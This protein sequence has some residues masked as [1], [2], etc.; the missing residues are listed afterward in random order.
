MLS[1]DNGS[2]DSNIQS[3]SSQDTCWIAAP[4]FPWWPKS[5]RLQSRKS[6]T[7]LLHPLLWQFC[8]EN[9]HRLCIHT[10]RVIQHVPFGDNSIT[11]KR[12]YFLSP[13]FPI[14]HVKIS[15]FK[16]SYHWQ[17]SN[18]A[19]NM[20]RLAKFSEDR[21]NYCR[22]MAFSRFLRC[23][24]SAILDI[25]K[26]KI[27]IVAMLNRVKI[28]HH[29]KFYGHPSNHCWWCITFFKI[30]AFRYLR[31]LNIRIFN[32]GYGSD[33]KYAALSK[34]SWRSV[35][36]LLRWR[37]FYFSKWR[38]STMDLL[39]ACLDNPRKAFGGAYHCANFAWNRYSSFANMQV[40][41]FDKSGLKI[42]IHVDLT[43]QVG[44]S[45]IATPKSI[46]FRRNKS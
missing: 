12:I 7:Y 45:L 1:N 23:R 32:C 19:I 4:E 37:F 24:P 11:G 5:S 44:S 39:C 15:L 21:S 16:N 26:F 38:P 46:S 33:G 35:K 17:E 9:I 25:L 36:S 10:H 31:F 43:P 22:D 41:I 14:L 18:K 3:R 29:T 27:L 40:L 30:V 34:I 28:R 13:F 42:P 8:L 2:N 20:H 6:K